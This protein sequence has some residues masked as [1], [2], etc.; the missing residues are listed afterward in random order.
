MVQ[1]NDDRSTSQEQKSLEGPVGE[2]MVNARD[3]PAQPACH[4]HVSQLAHRRIGDHP[5]D[6]VLGQRNGRTENHGQG[7]R[8]RDHIHGHG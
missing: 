1:G 4:H 7:S 3:V 6:V 2:Q 5:F 8:D